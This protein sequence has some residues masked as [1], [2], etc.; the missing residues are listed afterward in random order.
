MHSQRSVI[1]HERGTKIR[2][3]LNFKHLKARKTEEFTIFV[4]KKNEQRVKF[5]HRMHHEC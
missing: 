1:A 3:K 4:A 5:T 2:S